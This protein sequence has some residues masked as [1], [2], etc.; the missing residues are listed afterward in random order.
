MAG[1]DKIKKVLEK[2]K[3]KKA[4]T[5]TIKETVSGTK[6]TSLPK[7]LRAT[8]EEHFGA[9]LSKVRVHTGG[10]AGEIAKGISARAFVH[11]SDIFFAK[12]SSAS[13]KELLAHELAH[14]LQHTGGKKMPPAKA[15]KVLVSK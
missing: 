14:A 12:E 15:G 1:Q 2:A 9:N 10:N 6:S 13:N 11:G 7:D 5:K 3:G 8:L 4:K